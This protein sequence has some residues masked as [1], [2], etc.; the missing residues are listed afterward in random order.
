MLGAMDLGVADT[1]ADL[2]FV[3]WFDG[4]HP[5]PDLDLHHCKIIFM[6][7]TNI[8]HSEEGRHG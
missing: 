2:P 5:Q 4:F 8:S 1:L 3:R 7:V 6:P